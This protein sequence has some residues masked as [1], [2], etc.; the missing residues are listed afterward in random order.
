V[1]QAQHGRILREAAALVDEGKLRP[2]L[3]K[4]GFSPADIGAAYSLVESG[5]M[6]KVVVDF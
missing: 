4:Q 6:G 3:N 5:A 2:L 1:G